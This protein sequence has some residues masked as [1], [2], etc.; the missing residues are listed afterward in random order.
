MKPVHYLRDRPI[1]QLALV[2]AYQRVM[3][4]KPQKRRKAARQRE[5]P[6]FEG[7]PKKSLEAEEAKNG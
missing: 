4:T 6:L 7:T 5:L 2:L 3:G 1:T